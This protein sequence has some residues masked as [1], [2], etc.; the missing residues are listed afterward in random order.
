V[1]G[2]IPGGGDRGNY[3]L[4]EKYGGQKGVELMRKVLNR[5]EKVFTALAIGSV[6]MMV[7]LTT[8]DSLGRYLFNRPIHGSYEITE[9]YL[10]VIT[11]FFGLCYGYHKGCNIR[12]TFL[13][14]HLPRQI[15]LAVDY[16][17]QILSILCG[18][19]LVISSFRM[20]LRGIH[21]SLTYVYDIPLGPAYIVAPVGLLM[22]TLWLLYDLGQV[23]KGKSG[24]FAEEEETPIT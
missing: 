21:E 19:I 20:A 14:R 2:Q 5:I 17:V 15:K 8:V 3:V 22:L 7:C 9:R 11:V 6:L 10:M 23:K 12:V 24:L 13:V 4:R 16:I 1:E 18:I